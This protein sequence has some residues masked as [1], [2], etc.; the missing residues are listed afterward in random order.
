MMWWALACTP[1]ELP[2]TGEVGYRAPEVNVAALEHANCY[3][4]DMGLPSGSLD[5]VLD[6][7]TQAHAEYMLENGVLDHQEVADNPGFTGEWVWDR[8]EAAG[9]DT[10][11][12][13]ERRAAITQSVR[14]RQPRGGRV[15]TSAGAAS[16][17]HRLRREGPLGDPSRLCRRPDGHDRDP[18]VPA[19]V[20]RR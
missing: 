19:A 15:F 7:A 13:Q 4:L 9:F 8:M 5:P 10:V 11:S 14:V 1:D 12:R 20:R 2:C 16:D 17:I 18:N 3:R 6:D